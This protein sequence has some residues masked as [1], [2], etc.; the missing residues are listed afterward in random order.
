LPDDTYDVFAPR[1][2]ALTAEEITRAA[3]GH[4]HPDQAVVVAVGDCSRIT[5][6]LEAIGIG[7][8]AIVDVDL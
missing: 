6:G 7:C 5:A 1:I 2:H 8:A 3:A 4:L